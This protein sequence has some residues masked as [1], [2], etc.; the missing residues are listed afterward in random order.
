MMQ[1]L[2]RLAIF[3]DSIVKST[4]LF[5]SPDI[6]LDSTILS[7]VLDRTNRINLKYKFQP[8][9]I[10]IKACVCYFLSNFYFFIKLQPFKNYEKCFLF[11]QKSSFCSRDIQFFV[12]FCLPFHTFQL[13]KDKWKW[14]NFRC[15]ELTG[16]N[17]QMEFLQ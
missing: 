7:T 16:I 3:F 5:K 14:N 17:F 9:I 1:Q 11:H 12:I 2:I 13:E 15:H 10:S 8:S 6:S 4:N